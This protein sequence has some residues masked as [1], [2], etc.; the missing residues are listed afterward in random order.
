MAEL[1]NKDRM[2]IPRQEMPAQDAE[3]RRGNFEEV[4]LGFTLELAQLE[5]ERCLQ[6]AKP[7]CVDGCPV[8]VQDPGVHH[9]RCATATWP[10]PR[11][12]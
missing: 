3:V 6:C 12:R 8:G 7:H 2:K 1:T 10:A 4:A 5:A 9:G 11:R